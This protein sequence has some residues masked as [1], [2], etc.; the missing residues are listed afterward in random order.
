[1]SIIYKVMNFL[2]KNLDI[3]F[4]RDYLWF[5][6]KKRIFFK[7]LNH[8]LVYVLFCYFL[9]SSI[10]NVIIEKRALGIFSQNLFIDFYSKQNAIEYEKMFA[11]IFIFFTLWFILFVLSFFIRKLHEMFYTNIWEISMFSA[12][13]LI[14]H[15]W[16]LWFQ[17][18]DYWF[19]NV[20]SWFLFF[21]TYLMVVST[22]ISVKNEDNDEEDLAFIENINTE[23]YLNKN[24]HIINDA[25]KERTELNELIDS[26]T[27]KKKTTSDFRG[28]LHHIP[29][30]YDVD[31]KSKVDAIIGMKKQR[32]ED[33]KEDGITHLLYFGGNLLKLFPKETVTQNYILNF[34]RLLHFASYLIDTKYDPQETLIEMESRYKRTLVLQEAGSRQELH[35][36]TEEGK[37]QA[38]S[39]RFEKE[40]IYLDPWYSSR[41]YRGMSETQALWYT[42]WVSNQVPFVV[43]IFIIIKRFFMQYKLAKIKAKKRR[44]EIH[45][46]DALYSFFGIKIKQEKFII[47]YP[48]GYI[49]WVRGQP[50]FVKVGSPDFDPVLYATPEE[51]PPKVHIQIYNTLKKMF[52]AIK[53]IL[54]FFYN[55]ITSW[56]SILF[57]KYA[58]FSSIYLPKKIFELIVWVFKRIFYFFKRKYLFML[59]ITM[60]L[61]NYLKN[62]IYYVIIVIKRFRIF[63]KRVQPAGPFT[64][65]NPLSKLKKNYMNKSVLFFKKQQE[66]EKDRKLFSKLL[67]RTKK[68]KLFLL[69]S[70]YKRN[71]E[72]LK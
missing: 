10:Q 72:K 47:K 12:L 14:W 58:I 32:L 42:W 5:E 61:V 43:K 64:I 18:E 29:S 25:I 34:K 6:T 45:F 40:F 7:K 44:S 17:M 63:Y 52:I 48:D 53:S 55:I 69:W 1:M 54:L 24:R 67:K 39:K 46:S 70:S 22:L 62:N 37:L 50:V 2:Y 30:V 19:Q 51:T 41:W 11:T 9:L 60:P 16:N 3:Y 28:Q 71:N 66:I 57:W 65:Y 36:L 26:L 27:V 13:F 35:G 38:L 31:I 33:A 4:G 8:L 21:N 20:L 15:N 23:I 56:G 49:G 59:R 68:R